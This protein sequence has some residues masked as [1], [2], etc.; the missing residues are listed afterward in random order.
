MQTSNFSRQSQYDNIRKFKCPL[1]I[2]FW[3]YSHNGCCLIIDNTTNTIQHLYIRENCALTN[4]IQTLPKLLKTVNNIDENE[5]TNH[6]SSGGGGGVIGDDGNSKDSFFPIRLI[7]YINITTT[8]S[9]PDQ[10]VLANLSDESR[11]RYLK[12]NDNVTQQFWHVLCDTGIYIGNEMRLTEKDVQATFL[13][14]ISGPFAFLSTKSSFLDFLEMTTFRFFNETMPLINNLHEDDIMTRIDEC[15]KFLS[16]APAKR[17]LELRPSNS[18]GDLLYMD[19]RDIFD[20][21]KLKTSSPYV[22]HLR[23]IHLTN[24]ANFIDTWRRNLINFVH[25]FANVTDINRTNVRIPGTCGVL[26]FLQGNNKTVIPEFRCDSPSVKP[27]D[28]IHLRT[29]IRNYEMQNTGRFNELNAFN[30]GG[31]HARINEG[32]HARTIALSDA[33]VICVHVLE[34]MVQQYTDG[35]VDDALNF[36]CLFTNTVFEQKNNELW[37]SSIESCLQVEPHYTNSPRDRIGCMQMLCEK[38]RMNDIHRFCIP[39]RFL[40]MM[41]MQWA[42]TQLNL[43]IF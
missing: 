5:T 16:Q 26:H 40:T 19:A 2:G 23:P 22:T 29:A 18:G 3:H 15:V 6:N 11:K 14:Q 36:H 32:T 13:R 41:W 28:C 42:C 10:N 33:G 9:P 31:I 37:R 25:E 35:R 12:Y 8:T 39:K 34:A 1:N 43:N 4:N 27:E 7:P 24:E 21:I 20:V 17:M 30:E 38:K